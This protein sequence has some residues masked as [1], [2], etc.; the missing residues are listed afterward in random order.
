MATGAETK[1]D[2]RV[3]ELAAAAGLTVRTLHYYE[4]IG[5]LVPSSR[6]AAGHRLYTD[7]DVARLY[8]ILLLRRLGLP[9]TEIGHVMDDPAWD[10]SSVLAAHLA[11]L[12]ERLTAGA[13]LRSRLTQ[14][15]GTSSGATSP[16]TNDLLKLLEDM[17]ML[18]ANVRQRISIL[19]YS[20]LEAA[21]DHLTEVFGLGPGELTR[22]PDGNVVHGSVEAGDG[23]VWLHPE[24]PDFGLASPRT[25]GGATA[26]MAIMVDDVDAHHER[27]AAQG[28]DIVYEPVDQPYGY[29]EYSARDNEGGLWSFMK[30]LPDAA[31]A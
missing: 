24:A 20:D 17:T 25:L 18:D 5:L 21:F 22:D 29:R 27:A 9:L 4:E 8:R 10:L 14:L 30:P 2:R 16:P 6:T 28:A 3:G 26:T 31:P 11:T 15:L 1:Q 7:S 12:D 13:R 23:V 19:V